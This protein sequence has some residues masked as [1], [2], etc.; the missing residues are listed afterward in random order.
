MLADLGMLARKHE[1]DRSVK[2]V[3]F[4]SALEEISACH[5]DTDFLQDMSTEAVARDGAKFMPIEVAMGVL[6][7]GGASRMARQAGLGRAL[8]II[9]SARN[10]DADEAQAYGTINKA[11]APDN[12]GPYVDELA[13]RIAKWPDE[14]IDARKQTVYESIDKPIYNALCA[15]AYWLNQA[16]SNPPLHQTLCLGRSAE[17]SI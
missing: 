12:I 14:S 15:E 9:L 3:V 16:T 5:A 6:P 13:S 10:F 2:V 4:Q 11:L 8:N 1:R 17:S 7:C